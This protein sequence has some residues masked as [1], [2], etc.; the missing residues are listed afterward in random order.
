MIVIL[1]PL[2]G[3]ECSFGVLNKSHNSFNLIVLIVVFSSGMLEE[4]GMP[5]ENY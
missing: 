1:K 4:S 2:G 3:I 5:R